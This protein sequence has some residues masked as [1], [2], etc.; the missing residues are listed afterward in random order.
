M[1]RPPK[2]QFR[3]RRLPAPG[4]A[5]GTARR[6]DAD[7]DYR[8]SHRKDRSTGARLSIPLKTIYFSFIGD[9]LLPL[10]EKDSALQARHPVGATFK[11]RNPL[12]FPDAFAFGA[13]LGGGGC[14]SG[15]RLSAPSAT[16]YFRQTPEPGYIGPI[17]LPHC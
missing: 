12:A 4:S 8:L 13:L 11:V 2:S 6:F 5:N 16:S 15:G 3:R 10:L 9:R 17:R 14:G 7:P 1:D